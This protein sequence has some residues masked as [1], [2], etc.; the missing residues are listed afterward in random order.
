MF[1][2]QNNLIFGH[3]FEGSGLKS[4]YSSTKV[5]CCKNAARPLHLHNMQ[6]HRKLMKMKY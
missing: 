4:F 3:L 2:F 5:W 6:R 1:H